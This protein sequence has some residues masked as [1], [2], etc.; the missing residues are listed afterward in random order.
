MARIAKT[1]NDEGR[2]TRRGEPWRPGSVFVI[3]KRLAA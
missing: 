3:L 2:P 1:L